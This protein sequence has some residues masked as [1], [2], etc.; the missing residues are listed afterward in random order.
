MVFLGYLVTA[1]P[2]VGNHFCDSSA[3]EE[4]ISKY[5]MPSGTVIWVTTK[6]PC[7]LVNEVVSICRTSIYTMHIKIFNRPQSKLIITYYIRGKPHRITRRLALKL[8]EGK[9]TTTSSRYAVLSS[10]TEDGS[11]WCV[12]DTQVHCLIVKRDH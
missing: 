2:T 4:F 5:L 12:N 9:M 8:N 6:P 3:I 7:S 11:A 1:Q 10:A